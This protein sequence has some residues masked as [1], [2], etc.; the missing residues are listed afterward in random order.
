MANS[1]SGVN[2]AAIAQQSL[3]TLLP[4]LPMLRGI[5]STDFSA[6]VAVSG[7]SVTTR[8]ATATTAQDFTATSA[9]QDATTTA[10]TITL[11][12]YKGTRIGFTDSEWS[13]SSVNLNDVFIVPAVNGIANAIVQSALA[14]VTDANYGAAALNGAAS[15]LDADAAADLAATLT[16]ANVPV[17]GRFLLVGPTYY[18][19]LAKDSAVQAAYAY[20]S[21]EAIRENRIPKVHGLSVFEFTGIPSNS[22]ALVGMCGA[23][24]GILCATRLPAVPSNFP[25]EVE[26]VTDPDS[27]FSLQFRRWYSADD[28]KHRM[29][30]GIIYGVAVG[31][32]GNLKRITND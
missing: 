24:Q 18:A 29:E 26:T 20:G 2:L 1:L 22:E 12:N 10:K 5:M 27:G 6:D 28:R 9:D 15:A 32:A 13:K 14:L 19:N 4:K 17:D 8:V 25:G 16:A 11:G 31:V 23:K 30:V 21:P 7:E 3:S